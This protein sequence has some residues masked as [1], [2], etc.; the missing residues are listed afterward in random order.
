[1]VVAARVASAN[2]PMMT[3]LRIVVPPGRTRTRFTC[4]R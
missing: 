4:G 1:V 3:R 2:A